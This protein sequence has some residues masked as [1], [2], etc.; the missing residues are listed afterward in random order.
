VVHIDIL[1]R[2]RQKSDV[3][4]WHDALP[5][6]SKILDDQNNY[7]PLPGVSV[8]TQGLNPLQLYE[9]TPEPG[10]DP[11]SWADPPV[12]SA[13]FHANIRIGETADAYSTLVINEGESDPEL[14]KNKI[15]RWFRNNGVEKVD[16]A[17]EHP[18]SGSSTITWFRWQSGAQWVDIAKVKPGF[19]R[20]IWFGDPAN[21]DL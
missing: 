11:A 8:V 20:G 14:D 13:D 9:G 5:A 16:T 6:N 7:E 12:Y 4:A 18:R 3:G 19:R 2:A 17:G 1:L 10:V 15:R 21:P